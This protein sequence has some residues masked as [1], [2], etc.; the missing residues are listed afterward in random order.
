MR[1]SEEKYSLLQ[2]EAARKVEEAVLG[3]DVGL[4]GFTTLEQAASL[5][6]QLKLERDDVLLDIGAGR[7]WPGTHL[8]A[9]SGCSLIAAD[10]PRDALSEAKLR[11]SRFDLRS[12]SAAIAAD[13]QRLPFR[14]ASF[15][16]VSHA[17]VFC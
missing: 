2:S 11:I 16:A 12:V 15:N 1:P 3:R 8:A 13:G 14:A 4:S 9:S 10:I 7:G 6:R 17:D 5:Q